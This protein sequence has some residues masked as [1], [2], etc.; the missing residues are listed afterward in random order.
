MLINITLE[1]ARGKRECR[2]CHTSIN[3]GDK[4]LMNRFIIRKKLAGY[5]NFHLD[6]ICP[7]L[8]ERLREVQS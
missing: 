2:Y 5:D 4:F 7:A 1:T 6:C 8:E 3:P